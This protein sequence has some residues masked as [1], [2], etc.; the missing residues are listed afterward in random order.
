[1]LFCFDRADSSCRPIQT[2]GSD[3]IRHHQS[4]LAARSQNAVTRQQPLH[5]LSPVGQYGG[6]KQAS[7]LPQRSNLRAIIRFT[8]VRRHFALVS[9]LMICLYTEAARTQCASFVY[10]QL[11]L[12]RREVPSNWI[13]KRMSCSVDLMCPSFYIFSDMS[14]HAY[15]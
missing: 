6:W 12:I 2:L 13:S 7:I 11:M 14:A 10:R 15:Q 9:I 3:S 4:K 8:C 5:Q 1:M